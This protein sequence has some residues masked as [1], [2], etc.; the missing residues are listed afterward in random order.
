[1]ANNK[2]LS[3]KPPK[4]PPKLTYDFPDGFLGGM[5]TS[6]SPDQIAPNETPDVLNMEIKNGV[7][8]KRYGYRRLNAV[9]WGDNK[10]I[11]GMYEY[12]KTGLNNPFF[13]VAW[14]GKI[15]SVDGD[16]AKTNLCTGA[17]ASMAKAQTY[18]FTMGDKCYIANGTD[19]C[20]YDGTDPVADVVGYIPT[21]LTGCPPA[22]GGIA[23]EELNYLSNYW[24][25]TYS[26]SVDEETVTEFYLVMEADSITA[27]VNGESV[28]ATLDAAD[29]RRVN[30][31]AAPGQGTDH[32]E[33]TAYKAN[34]MSATN[35]KKCTIFT[36]YGGKNDTR[37]FATGNPDISNRVWRS[38]LLDPTYWPESA[39]DDIGSNAEANKGMGKVVDYLIYFKERTTHYGY[40]EGPD[41]DGDIAFPVLPMNDEYGCIAPR[42]ICP[43]HGGLLALSSK[44]VTF[45]IPSFVRG[46]LNVLMISEKVN[47]NNTGTGIQDFTV[48]ERK[49]AH[50]YIFDNKYWLHIKDLVWVLDLKYSDL[51]NNAVCWYP[52]TGTP[53]KAKQFL[54]RNDVLYIAD[55]VNGII[56]KGQEHYRDDGLATAINAYWTS[57]LLFVGG[58]NYI[59]KFERLLTTFSAQAKSQHE[60]TLITD[61]GNED[62]IL[63]QEARALDFNNIDFADFIF[64]VAAYPSSQS[65]KIGH[66]GE[67][68]Q[69]RLGNNNLDQ[70]LEILGQFLNFSISKEVR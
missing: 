13:L 22:G 28:T 40:V 2:P 11:L 38:G 53:G 16:G 52:F 9:S 32:V 47:K 5:N 70:G 18:F 48:D 57:P 4:V 14:D 1:M 67:Y 58:R 62:V 19:F 56:Y 3:F 10:P 54:E 45:T 42:T 17:K 34:L 69:W 64:G 66:K 15:Y 49:A 44:G 63:S 33:I 8:S 39:F 20:I 59:K 43:A 36:V 41:A 55:Q 7:W 26:C 30:F 68:L 50:A 29:K 25:Q 31:D 51:V 23:F 61:Q 60:L 24:K 65:E 27:K 21:V 12:W 46:Q 37:I 6:D 35:I